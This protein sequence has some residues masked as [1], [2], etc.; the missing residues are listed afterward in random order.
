MSEMVKTDIKI[1]RF[2]DG[3]YYI[4][5]IE[6]PHMFEA[7]LVNKE[8]GLSAMMCAINKY[9][10]GHILYESFVELVASLKDDAESDFESIIANDKMLYADDIEQAKKLWEQFEDVPMNPET[11][12]IE[13]DWKGFPIGTNREEIWHWFE[14]QFNISVAKDLMGVG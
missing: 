10:G 12:C 6:Y 3:D 11:E 8:S 1:T 4:D 7:K 13:S 2:D 9:D 5:V 14:E